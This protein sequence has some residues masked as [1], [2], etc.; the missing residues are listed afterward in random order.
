MLAPAECAIIVALL[1]DKDLPDVSC[2]FLIV[3]IMTI[4]ANGGLSLFAVMWVRYDHC[5]PFIVFHCYPLPLSLSSSRPTSW[6]RVHPTL[7]ET[8]F[9]MQYNMNMCNDK[10]LKQTVFGIKIT[11]ICKQMAVK[12][13]S[14]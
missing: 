10:E 14:S 7:I 1:F 3:H 9:A 4:H 6:I 11:S 12:L 13:S 8:K 2:S 5:D